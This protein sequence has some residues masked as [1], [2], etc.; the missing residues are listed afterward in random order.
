MIAHIIVL[1]DSGQGNGNANEIAC[2]YYYYY[3]YSL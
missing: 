2:C 3:Y 1:G